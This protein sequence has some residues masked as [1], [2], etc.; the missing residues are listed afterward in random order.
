MSMTSITGTNLSSI[1]GTNLSSITG[2][3][4]PS[5]D[6]SVSATVAADDNTALIGGVVGGAVALL[7]I[8]GLIAF[9]VMRNRKGTKPEVVLQTAT[10]SPTPPASS[11]YGPIGAPPL[12]D[13]VEVDEHHYDGVHDK[14]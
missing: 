11:N 8:V 9:I 14:L 2:T 4:L 6:M 1:T 13:V 10:A 5:N 3:N 7:L 12:Y